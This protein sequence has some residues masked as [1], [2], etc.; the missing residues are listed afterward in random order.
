MRIILTHHA[1]YTINKRKILDDEVINTI[2]FPEKVYKKKGK[3]FA[4]KD[5]GRG[6]IEV[7]YE[8]E[9]YIKVVTVYWL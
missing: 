5:I 9:N 4:Q 2:R 7:I 1:K 6:K 3:Y 8:K